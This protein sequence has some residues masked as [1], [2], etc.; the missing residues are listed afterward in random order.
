MQFCVNAV[1]IRQSPVV[2]T[3]GTLEVFSR[4]PNM[5][6]VKKNLPPFGRFSIRA[7]PTTCRLTGLAA[8]GPHPVPGVPVPTPTYPVS[9]TIKLVEPPPNAVDPLVVT[10]NPVVL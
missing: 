1:V 5:S 6:D 9:L 2:V 4:F 3:T 8:A 10:V 7:L